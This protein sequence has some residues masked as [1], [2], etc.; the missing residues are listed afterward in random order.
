VGLGVDSYLF[1]ELVEHPLGASAQVLAFAFIF[2]VGFS[3]VPF[4]FGFGL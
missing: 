3:G 4:L 2:A 1:T